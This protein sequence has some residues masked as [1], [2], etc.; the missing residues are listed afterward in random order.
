MKHYYIAAVVLIVFCSLNFAAASTQPWAVYG[1]FYVGMTKAEAKAVGYG[2]CEYGSYNEKEDVYCEIPS[3]KREFKNLHVSSAKLKFKHPKLDLVDEIQVVVKDD[4]FDV[5]PAIAA[6]YGDPIR[7]IGMWIR[8]T[9]HTISFRRFKGSSTTTITFG[10][11]PTLTK[12]IK[13]QLEAEKNRSQ[14][15]KAF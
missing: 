12:R 14:T 13:R 11:D 15:L 9:P 1:G 4:Y 8:D 5:E 6:R 2:A 10:F 7:D 3:S